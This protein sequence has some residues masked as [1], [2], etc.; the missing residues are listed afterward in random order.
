MGKRRQSPVAGE[1]SQETH[2]KMPL[3]N[4]ELEHL[5]SNP[6]K[7]TELSIEECC[8]ILDNCLNSDKRTLSRYVEVMKNVTNTIRIINNNNNTY[9]H[10]IV[11]QIKHNTNTINTPS[12]A[13][14]VKMPSP[15]TQPAQTKEP[16][17]TIIIKP[18]NN[19]NPTIIQAKIKTLLKNSSNKH[20]INN[21]YNTK[22]VVVIKTPN[23]PNDMLIDEIN[24]TADT[25]THCT[26]YTPKPLEPTIVIKNIPTDTD[27]STIITEI[28]NMNQE[29]QG[30]D[31]EFKLMF[32]LKNHTQ[33]NISKSTSIAFRVSPKVYNIIKTQLHNRVYLHTQCCTVQEKIFVKQC[34]KCF[35]F[36]HRTI[37]C[38]A[39]PQCKQCGGEKSPNHTCNNTC[40]TNC[41]KSDKHKTNT[42][43][44]PNTENCPIYQSQIQR[45]KDKTQYQPSNTLTHTQYSWLT[46]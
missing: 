14:V 43:H 46:H 42:N 28:T 11:N 32:Q 44:L 7:I 16:E 4:Q 33:T 45:I 6:S 39:K 5:L 27:L 3:E 17:N 19:T 8:N 34:Q 13:Q 24:N 15:Q 10:E 38:K 21:I 41:K 2:S 36:N 1:S 9:I 23:T 29:L 26:A 30:L 37:D 12:F 20:K 40:C 18:K 22:N 25:N 31:K 35:L